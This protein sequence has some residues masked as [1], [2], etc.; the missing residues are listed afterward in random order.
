LASRLPTEALELMWR[1]LE[2]AESVF[3]RCADSSGTVINIFHSAV[4]DL[5]AIAQSANPMLKNLQTRRSMHCYGTVTAS[6]TI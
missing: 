6:L 1:F 3:A 4:A 5:G 2:L